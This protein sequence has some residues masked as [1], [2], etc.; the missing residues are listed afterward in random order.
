MPMYGSIG[1]GEPARPCAENVSSR[2]SFS[3]MGPA[4][5][6]HTIVGPSAYVNLDEDASGAPSPTNQESSGSAAASRRDRALHATSRAQ[7]LHSPRASARTR[8][9]AR[10]RRTRGSGPGH[11]LTVPL[12]IACA[13]RPVNRRGFR[14]RSGGLRGR[15][16]RGPFHFDLAAKDR[17]P[18]FVIGDRHP[19]L[20]AD[21]DSLLRGFVVLA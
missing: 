1:T 10:R 8:F 5:R 16:F 6:R 19:A 9:R 2:S 11:L 13:A 7:R 4:P 21:P 17:T 3:T 20:D 14:A 12:T 18:L 15:G